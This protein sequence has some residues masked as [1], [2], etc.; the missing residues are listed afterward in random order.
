MLLP[1]PRKQNCVPFIQKL[2]FVFQFQNL[3]YVVQFVGDITKHIFNA[4]VT[5]CYLYLFGLKVVAD[6]F[7]VYTLFLFSQG[8]L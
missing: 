2:P 7:I 3:R 6:Y 1:E 8:H 4:L 5:S